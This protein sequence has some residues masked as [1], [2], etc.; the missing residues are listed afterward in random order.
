MS[1]Y[2]DK[3]KI[4]IDGCSKGNPGHAACGVVI[5]D[6]NDKTLCECSE[7]LGEKTNN[8]AEYGALLKALEIAPKYCT[9]D[10]EIHSDSQL[11]AKQM[12]R[13]FRIKQPHLLKLNQEARKRM[14]VFRNVSMIQVPREH[15]FIKKADKLADAEIQRMIYGR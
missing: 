7:Y 4:Y 9:L 8:E 3:I 15:P 12:N 14:L 11:V 2:I 10:I 5:L 13:Q 1:E 6:G